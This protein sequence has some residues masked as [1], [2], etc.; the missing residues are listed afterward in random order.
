MITAF[1][2]DVVIYATSDHPFAEQVGR[3]LEAGREWS[4]GSVLLIPEVLAKPIRIRAL[5][6]RDALV[7]VLRRIT[8]HPLDES[9][10]ALAT[11]LAAQYR[12]RTADAVHLATAV[13]VGADRFLTNNTKDFG[14][15]IAEIEIVTPADLSRPPRSA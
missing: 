2:A 12:L 15:E 4:V 13:A 6:E 14:G 3:V 1:D 7:A 11:T 5:E 8:L 9:T 10:A